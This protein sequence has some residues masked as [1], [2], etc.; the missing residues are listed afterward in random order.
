MTNESIFLLATVPFGLY[1][2]VFPSHA[3]R[4]IALLMRSAAR[5]QF[6]RF[7]EAETKARPMFIRIV[8]V[9]NLF[10]AGLIYLKGSG[11]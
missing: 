11:G 8:G 7:T 4:M 2:L 3:G 9:M 1:C 5:L 6:T 10:M